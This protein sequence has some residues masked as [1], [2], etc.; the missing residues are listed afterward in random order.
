VD[1][2]PGD[3]VR[4]FRYAGAVLLIVGLPAAACLR[5]PPDT[6]APPAVPGR[7]P[8]I[9][10][11][12]PAAELHA[13]RA[14]RSGRFARMWLLLFLNTSAGIMFIGLQSP[15]LQDLLVRRGTGLDATAL[16]GIGATLIGISSIFNGIGRFLWGGIS[17][18]IGR[19]RAFRLIFATQ[20]AVFVALVWT[21]NPWLFGILVCYV[22]LCYGGGFG[23]MPS[24]VGDVFGTRMMP[25]VYGAIL[26]AWSAAGIVGPQLAAFFKDRFSASAPTYTYCCGAALLLAGLLT[27]LT[28]DDRSA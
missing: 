10:A 26:T 1:L 19:T 11:P 25:L 22:L 21:T 20:L 7:A 18:K 9:A 5:N 6:F 28:L 16:A 2:Q 24:Y 23:T 17:D 12:A 13:G 4:V 3:L 15:M 8:A 14:L 27:S